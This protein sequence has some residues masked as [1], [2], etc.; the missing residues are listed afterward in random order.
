MTQNLR[1]ALV[2]Q[3]NL[4]RPYK[5]RYERLQDD[6]RTASSKSVKV[7]APISSRGVQR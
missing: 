6:P 1:D 5:D 3:D 4:V 7:A 2:E